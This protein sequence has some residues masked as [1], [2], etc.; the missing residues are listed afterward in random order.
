MT[1]TITHL[2]TF[3][4][5]IQSGEPVDTVRVAELLVGVVPGGAV[6]VADHDTVH[7]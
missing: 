6:H 5:N 4:V 7:S 3:L 2:H 1:R